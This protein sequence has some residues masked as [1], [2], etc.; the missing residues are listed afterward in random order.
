MKCSSLIAIGLGGSV[1]ISKA[2]G[3][4]PCVVGSLVGVWV[5]TSVGGLVGECVGASVGSAEAGSDVDVGI[6][7]NRVEAHFWLIKKSTLVD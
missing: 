3:D 4:G 6:A 7:V 2:L 1:G 5:G